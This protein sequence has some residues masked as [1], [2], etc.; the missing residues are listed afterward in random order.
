MPAK[1]R[2]AANRMLPRNDV[3]DKVRRAM[4][5]QAP[6][7]IGEVMPGS[8]VHFH[9]TQCEAEDD[10]MHIYGE[11][12]QRSSRR[13]REEYTYWHGEDPFYSLLKRK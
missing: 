13:S 3:M 10:K 2:M 4:L 8:R 9:Q 11:G 5:R 6:T 7:V 12:Q 1:S